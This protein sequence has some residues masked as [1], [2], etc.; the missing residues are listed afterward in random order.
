MS[1]AV[2]CMQICLGWRSCCGCLEVE[3]VMCMG[4][5]CILLRVDGVALSLVLL[6][7]C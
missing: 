7:I 2:S 3:I 5:G 4:L 1:W 6:G